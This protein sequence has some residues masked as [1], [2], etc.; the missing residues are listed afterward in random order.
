MTTKF[1]IKHGH[2]LVAAGVVVVLVSL[3]LNALG[4]E[5]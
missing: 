5:L 1:W 2:W 3:A 4:I